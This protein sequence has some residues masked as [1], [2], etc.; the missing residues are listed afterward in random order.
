MHYFETWKT[1]K[2]DNFSQEINVTNLENL[3]NSQLRPNKN[4]ENR[5]FEPGKTWKN[6]ENDPRKSV[7]TLYCILN[8][9][10]SRPLFLMADLFHTEQA[11]KLKTLWI[12]GV[13]LVILLRF[14]KIFPKF[15]LLPIPSY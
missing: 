5:T 1:W 8:L 13:N 6:L 2:M 12:G 14:L 11:L 7:A 10:G 3:E 15:L 9:L 4:L